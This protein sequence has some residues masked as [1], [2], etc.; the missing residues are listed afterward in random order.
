MKYLILIRQEKMNKCFALLLLIAT[1]YDL[2]FGE[3]ALGGNICARYQSRK[4]GEKGCTY[5]C[6]QKALQ[7]QCQVGV[8][9]CSW[10]CVTK[11]PK[12]GTFQCL[13]YPAT[14]N[15]C[16]PGETVSACGTTCTCS[17]QPQCKVGVDG[18][19]WNCVTAHPPPG[20][21]QCLAYPATPDQCYPGETVS[22]CGTTCTCSQQPQCKVGVDGC[23]WNCVT[24]VP[25]PG[26]F[27][28]LAYPDTPAKCYPGQTA[29]LCGTTCTCSQQPQCTVGVDGCEW[30]CV[31]AVPPPG[32]FQCLAYPDTPAKCYPGQIASICGTTCTCSKQL[33]C[34]VGVDGCS[35]DCITSS[36]SDG[37]A[38][39]DALPG[40]PDMCYPGQSETVCATTC[41]CNKS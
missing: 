34:K 32:T 20:T 28:C 15:K 11:P 17:Q 29:S 37:V 18:C 39:C 27:Q 22:V 41:T 24:A 10:T 23:E 35:W 30:N 3:L 16:I 5:N 2:A 13:A 26:T 33:E 4:V 25:P 40:T 19:E 8:K 6:K 36:P 12:P 9:G 7:P 31:T 1:C 21:F 38:V 14:P